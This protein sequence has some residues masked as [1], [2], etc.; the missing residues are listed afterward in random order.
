EAIVTAEE[1]A[2][3]SGVP[4]KIVEW[5][6]RSDPLSLPRVLDEEGVD[7]LDFELNLA[8]IGLVADHAVHPFHVLLHARHDRRPFGRLVALRIRKHVALLAGKLERLA[9]GEIYRGILV[10]VKR[11]LA[12]SLQIDR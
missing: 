2:H 9:F 4:F 3:Y 8:R 1:R 6:G 5:G 10:R 7:F 12:V 11:S